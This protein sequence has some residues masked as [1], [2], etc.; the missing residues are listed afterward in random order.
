MDDVHVV[1][2][3]AAFTNIVDPNNGTNIFL[4]ASSIVQLYIIIST[5]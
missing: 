4:V 2:L 5:E 1:D 3:N